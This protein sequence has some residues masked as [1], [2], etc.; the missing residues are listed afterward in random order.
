MKR[1]R[2]LSPQKFIHKYI[3]S[4]KFSLATRS[5]KYSDNIENI[6]FCIVD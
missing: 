1:S 2:A 6:Y 4:L 5:Y 3:I